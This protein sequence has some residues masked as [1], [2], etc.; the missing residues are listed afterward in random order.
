[1]VEFLGST[2]LKEDGEADAY[3]FL[4]GQLQEEVG[5]VES[6]ALV[7]KLIEA[8]CDL[9]GREHFEQKRRLL[10]LALGLGNRLL[11]ESALPLAQVQRKFFEFWSVRREIHPL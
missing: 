7:F 6:K 9:V 4:V 1:M 2:E 11:E 8:V 5:R 3:G 10:P